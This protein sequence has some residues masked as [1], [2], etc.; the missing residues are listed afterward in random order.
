MGSHIFEAGMV[1]RK[2]KTSHCHYPTMNSLEY[3][4]H[5]RLKEWNFL[6]CPQRLKWL[7]GELTFWGVGL[8]WVCRDW[9]CEASKKLQHQWADNEIESAECS[10]QWYEDLN[11]AWKNKFI[12]TFHLFSNGFHCFCFHCLLQEIQ[13]N[14]F[15][16]DI[17]HWE[18]FFHQN[19]LKE[20]GT[21]CP[22]VWKLISLHKSHSY[23]RRWVS[24]LTSV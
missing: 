11:S 3:R 2:L 21:S 18:A 8:Q 4:G 20:K 24:F 23:F 15:Q 14:L 6:E 9:R 12:E 19:F 7:H 16:L 13:P 22:S 17:P 1:K 10:M 5:W